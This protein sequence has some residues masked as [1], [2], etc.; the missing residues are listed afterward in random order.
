MEKILKNIFLLKRKKLSIGK[1]LV[2]IALV[3]IVVFINYPFFWMITTSLKGPKEVFRIPQTLMPEQLRWG[4]YVE[5]WGMANWGRYFI[6]TFIVAILPTAGQMIFGSLAAFA[7]TRKFR[8]SVF[9]FTMFLGTLMIPSQA[10]MVP[11]YIIINKLGWLNSYKA[12]VIPFLSSAFAVFLMRQFFL[13]IPK[14]LEDAAVIDGCGPFYYLFRILMPL[15]KSALITVGLF[16]FLERWNDFVWAMIMTTKD[17]LRTV[18]VGLAVYQSEWM[19]SWTL[20]MAACTFI[21][22]PVIILFLIGQK[23]FIEGIVMTGVKG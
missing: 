11:N 22:L 23:R 13:T 14:D 12:L 18:Q 7:F 6:N 10:I 21:S 3:M 8:G 16:A 1:I 20:L 4:N 19:I 5:A 17:S 15:S 9:L 2:Y